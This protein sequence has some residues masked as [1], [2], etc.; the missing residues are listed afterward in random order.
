MKHLKII[1][2]CILA[3]LVLIVVLQ[4]LEPAKPQILFIKTEMPLAVLIFI[5][6]VMGFAAGYLTSSWLRRSKEG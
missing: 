5:T 1:V 2:A 3:L 4:N 6:L